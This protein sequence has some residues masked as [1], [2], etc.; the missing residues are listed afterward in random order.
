MNSGDI[1]IQAKSYP[2]QLQ[3]QQAD[4]SKPA[5]NSGNTQA[6][7]PVSLY[8]MYF[9]NYSLGLSSTLACILIS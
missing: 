3:A 1:Y 9:Y 7:E 6:G 5:W 4:R 8:P 2:G